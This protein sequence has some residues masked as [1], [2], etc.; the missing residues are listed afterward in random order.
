[1]VGTWFD[2]TKEWEARLDQ[3][4]NPRRS[5]PK[6]QR[7]EPRK[8]SNPRRLRPQTVAEFDFLDRQIDFPAEKFDFPIREFD[9]PTREIEFLG[10]KIEFHRRCVSDHPKFP[11]A[12]T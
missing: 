4:G 7:G 12:I 11:G 9:F 5:S 8:E 1:M 3:L 10:Q 2:R 6:P